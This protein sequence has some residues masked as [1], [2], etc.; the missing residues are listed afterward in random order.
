MRKSAPLGATLAIAQ[1]SSPG[2]L[3]ACTVETI[4]D[5]SGDQACSNWN[6]LMNAGQDVQD[7]RPSGSA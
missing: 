3:M 6:Q 5:P 2:P 4:R 7:E 1:K